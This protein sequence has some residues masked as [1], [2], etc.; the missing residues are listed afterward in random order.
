LATAKTVNYSGF[1]VNGGSIFFVLYGAHELALDPNTA[2]TVE[3]FNEAFGTDFNYSKFIEII[4]AWK[5][6]ITTLAGGI[7]TSFIW[8]QSMRQKMKDLDS[9]ESFLTFVNNELGEIL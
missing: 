7:Q 9:P 6:H 2:A 1:A 5:V 4:E 8:Y 3:L